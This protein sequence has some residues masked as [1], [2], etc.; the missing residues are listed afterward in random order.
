MG[1]LAAACA[2]CGSSGGGAE[3]ADADVAAEAADAADLAETG[4]EDAADT[5]P[6]DAGQDVEDVEDAADTAPPCPVTGDLGPGDHDRSL[7][8]EGRTRS[9]IA[10]VPGAYDPA[11]PAAVVLNLHGYFSAAW[12]QVLFSGM[13]DASDREGFVVVYPD[14]YLSSWN[15]GSCCGQAAADDLDDVGLMRAIVEDL[16]TRLCVDRRRVYATGMSNGGYMSHRLGCEAAD[17]FAAI[18]PVAGAMGISGCDPARPLPVIAFHG[19][20]DR[21]VSYDDGRAAVDLWRALNDC[22]GGPVRTDF[23]GSRCET[24]SGCAAGVEVTLCTLDPMGHC[25]PGGSSTLCLPGIGPYNDDVD[26]N[27]A[28]WGFFERFPLAE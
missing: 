1:M 5:A 8:W 23:G 20:Q 10:H 17:L 19:A 15:G 14:G 9:Y 16:A 24:W 13:D 11:T 21:L 7:D 27:T 3:D 26:A 4:E 25:W 12:Q 28:M 6:D 2:A 22:T 18:A